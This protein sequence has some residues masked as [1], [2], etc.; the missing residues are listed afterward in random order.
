MRSS[1]SR[2]ALG[3]IFAFSMFFLVPE[4][5][6]AGTL[7]IYPANLS[8]GGDA[9]ALVRPDYVTASPDRATFWAYVKLP[10]GA[11]LTRLEYRG[12]G[13]GGPGSV[14][15]L[16]RHRPGLDNPEMLGAASNMGGVS[17]WTT[18]QSTLFII[19][20]VNNAYKHFVEVYVAPDN[21]VGF[22][23]ISYK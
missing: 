20:K 14:V 23:K 5:V 15:G 1:R 17:D 21:R 19:P 10:D 9:D 16:K 4:G 18:F 2:L 22:I 6:W 11:T 8:A 12:M 3:L 7:T 13:D